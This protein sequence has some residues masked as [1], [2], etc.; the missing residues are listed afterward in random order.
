MNLPP[1]LSPEKRDDIDEHQDSGQSPQDTELIKPGMILSQ[2]HPL[3]HR[4]EIQC[5][6]KRHHQ[7]HRHH[8]H[9]LKRRHSQYL[10]RLPLINHNVGEEDHAADNHIVDHKIPIIGPLVDSQQESR[11]PDSRLC[12][13]PEYLLLPEFPL[14]SPPPA[15]S[16]P[17]VEQAQQQ[18]DKEQIH[19]MSM[20]ISQHK[21][22]TGKFMDGLIRHIGVMANVAGGIRKPILVP[23]GNQSE[24]GQPRPY[25]GIDHVMHI[26]G[27]AHRHTCQKS[28]QRRRTSSLTCQSLTHPVSQQ[29]PHQGTGEYKEKS[30]HK[31]PHEIVGQSHLSPRKLREENGKILAAVVVVDIFQR[32][33]QVP[34]R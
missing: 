23:L 22:V 17:G 12:Q 7:G 6:R 34:G 16:H 30:S 24:I 11:H 29:L 9:G 26:A 8:F 15:P 25:P 3:C 20:Q 32:I 18:N 19:H 10:S 28:S 4:S 31:R 1:R 33:P 14:I 2:S 13:L 21:G 27:H 5:K